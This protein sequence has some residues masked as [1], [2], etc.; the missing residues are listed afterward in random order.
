M[1]SFSETDIGRMCVPTA[2]Q[3]EVLKI[4]DA[5]ANKFPCVRTLYIFGS[6]ARGDPEPGDI[7]I[8]IEYVDE[9]HEHGQM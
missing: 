2:K 4:A 8:A 7:D 9:V 6:F 1:R 5:W 3:I